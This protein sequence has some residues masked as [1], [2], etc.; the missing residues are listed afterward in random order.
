MYVQS[1]SMSNELLTIAREENRRMHKRLE[2]NRQ[3]TQSA[4]ESGITDPAGGCD[5]ESP[6]C[7]VKSWVADRMLSLSRLLSHSQPKVAG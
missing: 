2:T 3:I 4:A 7:S 1:G 6:R 5:R